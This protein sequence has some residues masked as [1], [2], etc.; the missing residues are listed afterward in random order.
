VTYIIEID[1]ETYSVCAAYSDGS[2]T[3]EVHGAK[4]TWNCTYSN[5]GGGCAGSGAN[6]TF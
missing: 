6:F 1:G 2:G 4:G 5:G 3:L